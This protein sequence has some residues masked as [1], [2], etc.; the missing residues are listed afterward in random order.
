MKLFITGGSGFIGSTFVKVAL[1]SGYKI[2]NVDALTYAASGTSLTSIEAHKNYLFEKIDI[3]DENNIASSLLR[4]RPDAIIHLAAETHVDRSIK[5]PNN[6]I[7]TNIDGTFKMLQQ[8]TKYW[9]VQKRPSSFRFYHISTDEV[10]GSLELDSQLKFHEKTPYNPNSPY[11]ASKA[12]SDHLV[13]A[14]S[15]T[16]GLPTLISN[17]S[18]NYGA[19]QF[20]EKFIP[21]SIVKSINGDPIP[22]YGNGENVRD[23]LHVDDH[24]KAIITILENGKP[25]TQYLIGGESEI[26][27]INLAAKICRHLDVIAPKQK[28]SYLEQL[29]HVPDRPG[30]DVRYAIDIRKISEELNW[31]PT[32]SLEEGIE[33]TV[34]WYVNNEH[35]WK[36]LLNKVI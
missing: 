25:G 15:K 33:S 3:C 5:G 16:Y 31:R 22:I 14:W 18:N 27:N 10:F 6:F 7:R 17:C 1:E 19:F 2:I 11:S 32:I 9:E 8:A 12:S 29:S 28:G 4:H 21:L 36:P 34:H 20:P 24:S 13:K 35:W 26:S 30:H 23:W